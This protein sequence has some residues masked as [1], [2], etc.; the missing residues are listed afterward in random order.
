MSS[1]DQPAS[2][3]ALT[4][5]N[6]TENNGDNF[7]FMSDTFTLSQDATP[8]STQIQMNSGSRFFRFEQ[9][10]NFSS[11]QEKAKQKIKFDIA[12]GSAELWT[13]KVTDGYSIR[14][15]TMTNS[16]TKTIVRCCEENSLYDEKTS[17]T[18]F[19]L[20]EKNWT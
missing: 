9:N 12:V 13:N 6:E 8:S 10:E 18:L 16:T 3:L 15:T 5:P 17:R 19:S 2:H 7:Q 14:P 11:L 1:T 4:L 20:Q